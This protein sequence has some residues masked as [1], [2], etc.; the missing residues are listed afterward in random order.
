MNTLI[1]NPEQYRKYLTEVEQLIEKDPVAGSAAAERLSLLALAIEEFEKNN[2]QFRKPTA[3][4]AIKFRMDEQGLKQSDLVQFIGSKS[5]VSEILAGKRNLTLPMIRALN[6]HLGIS[7][8]VLVSNEDETND[9]SISL[10]EDTV[11]SSFPL[12]E[13]QKRNWISSTADEIK[14][15]PRAVLEAFLRPLGGLTPQGAFWRRSIH[16]QID[17]TANRTGL[18]AWS[19]RVLILARAQRAAAYKHELINLEFMREVARL[20]SFDQGPLLVREFLNKRGIK[21]VV[22][23]HLP[24]TKL[25]GGCLLDADGNPVIGL[26]LRHDRIDYFWHTLLH[27]LA[28]VYKHLKPGQ[29]LFLDDLEYN[30]GSVDQKE[31]EADNIARDSSIPRAIWKRSEAFASQTAS[32]I[33]DLARTLGIHPAIVAGRL[34][35]ETNNYTRFNDLVGQGQVRKMFFKEEVNAD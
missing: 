34:R 31:R 22:E 17:S 18:I 11:C 20:S 16:G 33:L 3:I 32:A 25:D 30:S 7:L 21:I 14:K 23:R 28:H 27:E 24:K 2:F 5:K 1:N 26:T 12:S 4:E 35:Y 10:D 29:E 6:K 15:N 9:E 13:M 19:A 8:D